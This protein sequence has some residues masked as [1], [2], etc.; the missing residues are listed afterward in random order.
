VHGYPS[1]AIASCTG[2]LSKLYPSHFLKAYVYVSIETKTIGI[3]LYVRVILSFGDQFVEAVVQMTYGVERSHVLHSWNTVYMLKTAKDYGYGY[4]CDYQY[5]LSNSVF[6]VQRTASNLSTDIS[7][8]ETPQS[9]AHGMLECPAGA[10]YEYFSKTC[11]VIFG[12]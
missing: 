10:R 7:K 8:P 4:S 3:S 9:S 6:A 5:G 12:L 11:I 2:F 1:S